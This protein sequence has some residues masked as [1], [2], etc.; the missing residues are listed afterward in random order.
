M[1]MMGVVLQ[2]R[3]FVR[4]RKKGRDETDKQSNEENEIIKNKKSNFFH[5]DGGRSEIKTSAV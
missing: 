1:D 4:I 2:W 3:E 5:L